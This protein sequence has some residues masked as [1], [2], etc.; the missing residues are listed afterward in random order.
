MT[1]QE[2]RAVLNPSAFIGRCPE[3]VEKYLEKIKPLTLGTDIEE[4]EITV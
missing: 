3:Q 4:E 2:I 1:E